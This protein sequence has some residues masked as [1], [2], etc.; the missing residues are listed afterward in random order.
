MSGTPAGWEQALREKRAKQLIQKAV[1]QRAS[2]R[3]GRSRIT[4]ILVITAAAALGLILIFALPSRV[5]TIAPG[6][7]ALACAAFS[8]IYI[9]DLN[10]ARPWGR[11]NPANCPKCGQPSLRQKTMEVAS[12]SHRFAGGGGATS[13]NIRTTTT[14][15]TG[16]VILC[17]ADCGFTS[18]QKPEF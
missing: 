8:L 9:P 14:K 17:T 1:R 18:L 12:R 15:W 10:P 3:S 13:I 6:I 11:G 16:I 4:A 2:R 7:V 5:V